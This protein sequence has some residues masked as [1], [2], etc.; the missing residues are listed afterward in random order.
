VADEN[1]EDEGR[2][3]RVEIPVPVAEAEAEAPAPEVIVEPIRQLLRQEITIVRQELRQEIRQEIRAELHIGPLPHERTLE[4][5][6]RI[7]PGSAEKIIN[8]F[9]DQGEHRRRIESYAIK[10]DNIRSFAGLGA[11]FVISILV[12]ILAYDLIRTGHGT[13]GTILASVDLVGLVAVF[14]YGTHIVREERLKKAEIMVGR[15]ERQKQ[16]APKELP[17]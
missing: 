3:P 13:E 12:M 6:E 10:W 11:G 9:V 16:E 2:R 8:A 1:G 7:V 17:Q 14:V 15:S 4:G 5:Y